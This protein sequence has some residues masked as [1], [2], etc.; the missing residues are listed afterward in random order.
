MF[1]GRGARVSCEGRG[2]GHVLGAWS[3]GQDLTVSAE[4][5]GAVGGLHAGQSPWINAAETRSEVCFAP[6]SAAG[7]GLE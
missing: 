6:Q 1:A 7:S 3:L 2:L 5:S 4:L